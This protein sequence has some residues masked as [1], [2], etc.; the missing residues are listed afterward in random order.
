M[1]RSGN[2]LK[3]PTKQRRDQHV[4]ARLFV[5]WIALGRGE[6]APAPVALASTTR[7]SGPSGPQAAPEDAALPPTSGCPRRGRTA[8][9]LPT[10]GRVA[11]RRPFGRLGAEYSSPVPAALTRR[12]AAVRGLRCRQAAPVDAEE[13]STTGDRSSPSTDSLAPP[14]AFLGYDVGRG[15]TLRRA[16][17]EADDVDEPEAPSLVSRL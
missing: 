16:S 11:L 17:G 2:A 14:R 7:A 13:A 4:D 5:P 12:T 1:P 3:K 9:P 8:T 6:P 10:R 15:E